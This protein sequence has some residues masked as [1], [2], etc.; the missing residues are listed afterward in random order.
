MINHW[1]IIYGA[2][3]NN[4]TGEVSSDSIGEKCQGIT[5]EKTIFKP[6]SNGKIRIHRAKHVQ[7]I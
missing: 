2:L 3:K 5:F 7:K 1:K 4:K 6:K